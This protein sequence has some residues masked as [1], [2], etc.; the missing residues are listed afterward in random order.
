MDGMKKADEK[1]ADSSGRQIS[2]I[3][4]IAIYG[5]ILLAVFL[6]GFI[7]MWLTAR[8]RGNDLAETSR[9]LK[10][11]QMQNTLASAVI[12]ARRGEYETARQ[13]ASDFF[14]SLGAE[15]QLGENS[16]LTQ[17]QVEGARP[18]LGQRDEIITLLARSD[19]ASADRLAGL[20]VEYRKLTGGR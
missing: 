16:L 8:D 18:L 3:K 7:P 1:P 12:D 5:T 19:P 2:L 6:I 17:P 11:V 20:Y 9:Q 10:A 13:S 4:K 15:I 14:T